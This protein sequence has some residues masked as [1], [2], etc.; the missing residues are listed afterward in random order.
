MDFLFESVT[1][2]TTSSNL[3]VLFDCGYYILDVHFYENYPSILVNV[4]LTLT[5][6]INSVNSSEN[7]PLN[8]FI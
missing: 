3:F 2:L 4:K 7:L 5:C 6:S 1:I 8:V